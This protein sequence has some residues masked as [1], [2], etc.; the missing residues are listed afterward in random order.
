MWI[1]VLIIC[2]TTCQMDHSTGGYTSKER[3]EE[4]VK[5]FT[6]GD[7]NYRSVRRSAYCLPAPDDIIYE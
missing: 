7:A 6:E 1:L 5:I 3:C 4:A 2:G